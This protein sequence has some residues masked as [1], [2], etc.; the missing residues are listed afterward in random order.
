MKKLFFLGLAL[1]SFG[2]IQAKVVGDTIMYNGK[3]YY[4]GPNKISNGS[5]DKGFTGWYDGTST[6]TP[7]TL[8]TSTNWSVTKNGGVD[9]N[10]LISNV[11]TGKAGAGSLCTAWPISKDSIYYFSYYI[12]NRNKSTDANVGTFQVV[13]A[14]NTIATETLPLLGLGDK[15][16]NN[17]IFGQTKIASGDTTWVQNSFTFDNTQSDRQ[18]QYMQ[19][20]FRWENKAFGFDN[21]YLAPLLDASKITK[22]E[23]I[24]IQFLAKINELQSLSG[25]LVDRSGLCTLCD[26]TASDMYDIDTENADAMTAGITKMDSV[27]AV[28]NQAITDIATLKSLIEYCQ[29]IYETTLYQGYDTY[30]SALE[31]IKEVYN[32]EEESTADDYAKAI[33]DL[34][35]ALN[36][37]RLSQVAT[38]D[39]PADYTFMI[40]YPDFTTAASISE[41]MTDGTTAT[42]SGWVKGSTYTGGDQKASYR[43]GRDCWNAWWSVNIATAGTGNMDVHQNLSQ[44]PNGYYAISC[45]AITQSGCL[46]NQHAYVLSSAGTKVS[47]ILSETN[48]NGD[49]ATGTGKWDTLTT[50]KIL[51]SDGNLTI[52]FTSDKTNAVDGASSTADNREGWWCATDFQLFY[53][54]AAGDDELT[55]AYNAKIVAANALADTMHFAYDKKA[56]LDVI[57]ANTG[58]T[59]K[60]AM[61]TAMTNIANA[62]TTATNSESKYTEI[63]TEGKTIPTVTDSLAKSETAYGAANSI[64]K[65]ALGKMTDFIKA[66]TTTYT[67]VDNMI[68]K[69]KKYTT[70]YTAAYNAVN[71]SINEFTS[72]SAKEV[73][74]NLM[75]SQKTY[76]VSSDTLYATALIDTCITNINKTMRTCVAQNVYEKDKNTTDYTFMI[77]NPNAGGTV[78]TTTGWV[79]NRGK[80]NTD[81]AAGQHYSGNSS[82][83]YFDSW[84]GTAGVLN[85]YGYQEITGIPNGTYTVKAAGR[86]GK[87]KSTVVTDGA[88]IFASDG[89][90]LKSDTV[91]Q[92]IKSASYTYVSDASGNDT[93][94]CQGD[95]YGQIWEIATA[96]YKADTAT[97]LQSAEAAANNGIGRG[98][99][100]Y[101]LSYEVT[102]HKIVIGMCTD[103]LRTGKPFTGQWFSVVDFTLTKTADGDNTDWNGPIT[104]V[105]NNITT[106][107]KNVVEG[108]YN[109]SGVKMNNN[110]NLPKGIYI[111]KEG[112]K[113]KKILVK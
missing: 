104:G 110:A 5:F 54:G 20:C 48:W 76:L 34:K 28:T 56:F 47:P 106:N 93:T 102:D 15:S 39:T 87:D 75:A 27:I 85:Y 51:V 33:T 91:W 81:T 13:S 49:D 99:N 77:Q 69:M 78:N 113:T 29:T 101:S 95:S 52:G 70:D 71:D 16:A 103:S 112:N 57:A 23:L 82:L 8:I 72:A 90:S 67:S 111:V 26:E 1:L 38:K 61:S 89:G 35:A 107:E 98:W 63:F 25:S 12:S 88:F 84:N 53:Y 31:S 60:D 24:Q 55:A 14:T 18:Y 2:S 19:V 17:A 10:W 45:A 36:T 4:V 41:Q 66:E 59:D 83:R 43:Q 64:V 6:T 7:G 50:E 37:Y 58:A 32:N 46:T 105:N 62:M 68:T 21:F 74:T 44:L 3:L 9:G 109:L 92:E 94:V 108:I 96:A 79:I 80:G 73:L 30:G 40:S 22:A 86:N 100:W 11:N 42:S 65:Y 97:T